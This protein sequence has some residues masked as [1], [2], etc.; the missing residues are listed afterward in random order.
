[1]IKQKIIKIL[2]FVAVLAIG[3]GVVAT[4]FSQ[5]KID[6][7]QAEQPEQPEQPQSITEQVASVQPESDNTL[8]DVGLYQGREDNNFIEVKI[9]GDFKVLMLSAELRGNFEQLNLQFNDL[10]KFTYVHDKNGQS[11]IVKLEKR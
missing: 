9:N 6:P 10:I 4:S 8:T 7:E 2:L 3:I 11:V 5:S 1:M